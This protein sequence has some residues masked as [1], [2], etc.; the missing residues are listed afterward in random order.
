VRLGRHPIFATSHAAKIMRAANRF[1]SQALQRAIAQQF[2]ALALFGRR[3]PERV[4]GF[5]IPASENLHITG[6]PRR[7]RERGQRAA[8]ASKPDY[9][10]RDLSPELLALN[11]FVKKVYSEVGEYDPRSPDRPVR[12]DCISGCC[13]RKWRNTTKSLVAC[14]ERPPLTAVRISS[15][16]IWRIPSVPPGAFTINLKTLLGSRTMVYE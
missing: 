2:S 13:S 3:P 6:R 11:S 14:F 1:P 15:T 10:N 8:R 9:V 7:P 4:D 12:P 5:V 16:I